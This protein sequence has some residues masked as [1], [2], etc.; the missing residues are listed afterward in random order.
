MSARKEPAM[1]TTPTLFHKK[2]KG[3]SLM[4]LAVSLVVMIILVTGLLELGRLMFYYVA[5]RDAAQ[6]GAVYASLYPSACTQ[7]I[8][9]VQKDLYNADPTQVDV[10]V[11]IN[12]QPCESAATVDAA[13]KAAGVD[14]VHGCLPSYPAAGHTAIVQVRQPN[15]TIAVPMLG[16]FLGSQTIDIS[17]TMT[18]TIIRPPCPPPP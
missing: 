14:L 7:T 11:T 9:R 2:E 8:L 15:Y 5:M 6:E 13:A 12:G 16:T 10:T 1:P 4:E 17:A 18:A 3:Q